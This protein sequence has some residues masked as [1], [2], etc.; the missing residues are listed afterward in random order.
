MARRLILASQSP[1]RRQLLQQ[2]G[3]ACEVHAADCDEQQLIDECAADYVARVA[4]LKAATV[5]AVY[6]EDVIL[7]ADTTVTLSGHILTKPLDF[8]DACRMWQLLSGKT[9]EVL[10]AITVCCGN[11]YQTETVATQVSFRPLTL[12]DMQWYWN[13]GEPQ[14]K[15][16]GYAIQGGAAAWIT[17]LS[18]SYSNVVGLPLF[19]TL[20]LLK[21][22]GIIPSSQLTP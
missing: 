1:R 14:D 2:V 8:D 21:P 16:A 19:E 6:P 12:C 9:H 17:H 18:G 13:T 3:I 10:T 15:A 22:F 7:A 20:Q 5:A 4:A 11:Q